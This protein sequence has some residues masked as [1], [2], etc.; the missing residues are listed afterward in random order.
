MEYIAVELGEAVLATLITTRRICSILDAQNDITPIPPPDAIK[1]SSL[2]LQ[3]TELTET[4]ENFVVLKTE[5][6]ASLNYHKLRYI[7]NWFS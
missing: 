3:P 6:R 4:E 7:F 5:T 1:H 2:S